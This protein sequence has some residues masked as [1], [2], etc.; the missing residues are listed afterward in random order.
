MEISVLMLTVPSFNSLNPQKAQS[1]LALNFW[2]TVLLAQ[3][4]DG[5]RKTYLC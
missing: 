5:V 2:S 4:F 1:S 3:T